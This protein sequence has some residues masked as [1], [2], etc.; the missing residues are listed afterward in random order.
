MVQIRLFRMGSNN[1]FVEDKETLIFTEFSTAAKTLLP[2][3]MGSKHMY[4]IYA[5]HSIGYATIL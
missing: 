4:A 5:G 3:G 1:L 2:K